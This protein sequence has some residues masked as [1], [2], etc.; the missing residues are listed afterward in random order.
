MQKKRRISTESVSA[1]GHGSYHYEQSDR[2]EASSSGSDEPHSDLQ[3]VEDLSNEEDEI[4][5][6]ELGAHDGVEDL[7]DE[8]DDANS[9]SH[10]RLGADSHT[11]ESDDELGWDMDDL[12]RGSM[13]GKESSL[14]ASVRAGRAVAEARQVSIEVLHF[15]CITLFIWGIM[16]E[17]KY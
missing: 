3:S 13:D 16:Q 11:T 4:G 1:R 6:G 12:L 7:G 5:T 9:R 14:L 8:V 2:L 15:L 17:Y 10:E